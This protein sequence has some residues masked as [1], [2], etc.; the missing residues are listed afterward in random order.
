[1][2]LENKSRAGLSLELALIAP[3]D[4]ASRVYDKDYKNTSLLGVEY[5]LDC[6]ADKLDWRAL[7]LE[8]RISLGGD[9]TVA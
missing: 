6:A 5:Q 2:T 7:S 9:S 3:T 8:K 4:Q 1:M